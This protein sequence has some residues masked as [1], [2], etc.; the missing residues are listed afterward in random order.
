[1]NLLGVVVNRINSQKADSV[2]GYNF[3]YGYGYE[4][5]DSNDSQDKPGTTDTLELAEHDTDG[6]ATKLSGGR[7]KRAA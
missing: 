1:M 3:A 7:P 2:Y 6:P 4:Y 5:G